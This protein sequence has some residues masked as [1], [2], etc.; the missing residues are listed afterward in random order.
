MSLTEKAERRFWDKVLLPDGNGCMLWR[1]RIH[2]RGYGLFWLNGK[3][4]LAHRVSYLLAHGEIPAGLQVDHVKAR[5]CRH[6]H[7]VAPAHLEAVTGAE[8]NRRSD[9][10]T[11]INA[12]K[13]HCHRG[14]AF[15]EAN[16]YNDPAGQRQCRA[17][18]AL[19]EREYKKRKRSA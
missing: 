14:H 5:G 10:P 1:A 12:R 9:S 6:R 7:C 4:V 13:T 2:A 18:R 11:A 17:C 16:T 15:D 8:N 3:Y 19:N